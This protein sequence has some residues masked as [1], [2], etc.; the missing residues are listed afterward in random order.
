[1]PAYVVD[2]RSVVLSIR[3]NLQDRYKTRFS[4][5]KELIQ[6]ADDNDYEMKQVPELNFEYKGGYLRVDCNEKGLNDRYWPFGN[7]EWQCDAK[8]P[9]SQALQIEFNPASAGFPLHFTPIIDSQ[10]PTA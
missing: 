4:I 10:G 9:A 2:A 5:L 7:P 8:P 6:N 3:N 1:M